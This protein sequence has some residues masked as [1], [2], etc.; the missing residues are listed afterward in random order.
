[1]C[2]WGPKLIC[3]GDP[4]GRIGALG[5]GQLQ[6]VPYLLGSGYLL[7]PLLHFHRW[8]DCG[9]GNMGNVPG[10]MANQ[11]GSENSLFTSCCPDQGPLP[12]RTDAHAPTSWAAESGLTLQKLA[13]Q[14]QGFLR[15]HACCSTSA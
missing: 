2:L 15:G 6:P 10:P 12:T 3:R 13:G 1:M 9:L 14:V 5:E 4:Q 7:V 11:L 8:G